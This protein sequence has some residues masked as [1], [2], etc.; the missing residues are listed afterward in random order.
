M[1]AAFALTVLAACKGA[2]PPDVA[3]VAVSGLDA[4][5]AAGD[6]GAVR[7]GG[8]G[9]APSDEPRAYLVRDKDG[10]LAIVR[11]GAPSADQIVCDLGHPALLRKLSNE[12]GVVARLERASATSSPASFYV[13]LDLTAAPPDETAKRAAFEQA[14][15]HAETVSGDIVT[16]RVAPA[17]FG[18]LLGI[19]WVTSVQTPGF[20]HRR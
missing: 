8:A 20:G 7:D 3:V 11:D 1:H 17:R 10:G 6:A 19:P 12:R 9:A 2:P 16:V 18:A 15:A 13:K 5:D 14:G 4:G